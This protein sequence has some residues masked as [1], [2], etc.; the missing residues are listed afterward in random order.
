MIER[1]RSVMNA[2]IDGNM[3]SPKEGLIGDVTKVLMQWK[4]NAQKVTDEI[5]EDMEIGLF[6]W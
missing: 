2:V 6:D 5:L 3:E 1:K 4:K